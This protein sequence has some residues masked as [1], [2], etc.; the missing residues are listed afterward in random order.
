[1]AYKL[2]ITEKAEQDLDAI[3]RY[4]LMEFGDTLGR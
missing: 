3:L 4:I 2:R 1:M